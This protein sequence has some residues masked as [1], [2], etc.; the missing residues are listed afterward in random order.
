MVIKYIIQGFLLSAFLIS[1][2][3]KKFEDPNLQWSIKSNGAKKFSY[4]YALSREKLGRQ[5]YN[6][7][8]QWSVKTLNDLASIDKFVRRQVKR[9]KICKTYFI[10]DKQFKGNSY[11]F[12]G[13]CNETFPVPSN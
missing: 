8:S 1:C 12:L 3:G 4:F 11:V 5:K 10:Y 9:S 13:E 7:Q 6:Y 2:A